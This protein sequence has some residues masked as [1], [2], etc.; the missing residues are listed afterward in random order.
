MGRYRQQ[1]IFRI[2][3]RNIVRPNYQQSEALKIRLVQTAKRGMKNQHNN[4]YCFI[5]NMTNI[6]G[7]KEECSVTGCLHM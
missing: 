2:Q 7:I 6:N 5:Y 1:K 3:L 4:N